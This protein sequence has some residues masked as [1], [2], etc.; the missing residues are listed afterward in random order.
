MK[1]KKSLLSMVLAVVA[2]ASLPLTACGGGDSSSDSGSTSSNSSSNSSQSDSGAASDSAQD[3]DSGSQAADDDDAASQE[4]VTPP[5]IQDTTQLKYV[6]S[7]LSAEEKALY[8]KIVDAAASCSSSVQLDSPVSTEM[9]QKVFAAVYFQESQLFWLQG[10]MESPKETTIQSIP[11]Y[12]KNAASEIAGMQDKINAKVDEIIASIPSDANPM[13][14]IMVFH[15]WIVL[16]NNFTKES[17][18]AQTIYGAFV[19]GQVQCEG[20]AKAMAYLCDKIGIPN[21]LID[22]DN[23]EG[24]T[25]AWNAIQLDG[26][27]YNIDTTWDDPIL[28]PVVEKNIRYNFFNVTDAEIIGVTH[29]PYDQHGY[30]RPE[31]NGTKYNYFTYTNQLASSVDE[32]KTILKNQ[33]LEAVKNGGVTVQVRCSSSEILEQVKAELITNAGIYELIK[34]VNQTAENKLAEKVSKSGNEY[35]NCLQINLNYA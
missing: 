16:N 12:Y 14:K 26:E 18:Y 33:M 1:H 3:Q 17:A 21:M 19:D 2:G 31:C 25:H 35:L 34:E 8:D 5:T 28:D 24:Q 4:P 13:E 32:A 9:Y 11:L 27:W 15:D 10:Y 22:G 6:Y 20:Y 29:F 23:S 7:S 30:E